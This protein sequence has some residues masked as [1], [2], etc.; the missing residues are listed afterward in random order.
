MRDEGFREFVEDQL[1]GLG[2][3][4]CRAMFG[5]YG[6][7]RDEVFFGILYRSQVF[8]KTDEK[9]RQA[10]VEHGMKPF[11]P[12]ATQTLTS[13]YEVPAAVLEDSDELIE[14]AQQAVRYQGKATRNKIAR[15]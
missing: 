14:W 10:Y 12:S 1:K 3:V 13:Y 5:G 8:F 6:L 7:Y 9:T 15:K 11:R 2:R 4:E